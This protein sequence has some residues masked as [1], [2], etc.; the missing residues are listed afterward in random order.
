[1]IE[2]EG[3]RTLAEMRAMVGALRDRGD[4]DLAPQNGVA[5][6]ERLASSLGDEPRVQ[7]RLTGDLDAAQPGGRGGHV[8]H[9]PG[10]GD[11]RPAACAQRHPDRRAGRR[12]AS[13]PYG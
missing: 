1:M 4:A 2:E 11:E 6:I 7:V 5:D 12:R 10:V 9:R 3:S 8:P 13:T